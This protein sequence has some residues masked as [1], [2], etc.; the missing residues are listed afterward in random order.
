MRTCARPC[1]PP[2]RALPVHGR[3]LT[4]TSSPHPPRL[5]RYAAP[6]ARRSRVWVRAG[7]VVGNQGERRDRPSAGVEPPSAG[8]RPIRTGQKVIPQHGAAHASQ[9]LLHRASR[10]RPLSALVGAL[11]SRCDAAAMAAGW[12]GCF[13]P[14]RYFCASCSPCAAAA[15]LLGQPLG[16]MVLAGACAGESR[17]KPGRGQVIARARRLPGVLWAALEAT[18][19]RALLSRRARGAAQAPL[20]PR[21]SL[22]A[23]PMPVHK[24]PRP[25]EMFLEPPPPSGLRGFASKVVGSRLLWRPEKQPRGMAT[26]GIFFLCASVV[27]S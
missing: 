6:T 1:A 12:A 8:P 26:M 18:S 16:R 20:R 11:S 17:V 24:L 9:S 7:E 5:G 25:T 10:C 21:A 15:R 13:R 14:R 27:K 4:Y 19:R 3:A 2:R 22:Q 23:P